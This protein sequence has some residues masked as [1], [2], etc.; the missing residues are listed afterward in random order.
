M[1]EYFTKPLHG[2]YLWRFRAE[3]KGFQE[4]TPNIDLGYDITERTS[5]TRPQECVEN[6]FGRQ[7]SKIK[8]HWK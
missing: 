4:D 3:I 8:L 2:D 1:G 7:I 6:K 5:I